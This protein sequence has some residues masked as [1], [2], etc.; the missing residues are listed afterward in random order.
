MDS[1]SGRPIRSLRL[2]PI[3]IKNH[4]KKAFGPK[5]LLEEKFNYLEL[6]RMPLEDPSLQ[7]GGINSTSDAILS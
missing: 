1:G 4:F 6:L 2:M 7:R 5:S 3:C